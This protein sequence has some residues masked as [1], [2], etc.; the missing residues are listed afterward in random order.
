MSLLTSLRISPALFA[1][2]TS[3]LLF[4]SHPTPFIQVRSALYLFWL[5]KIKKA[6]HFRWQLKL[7]WWDK[8]IPLHKHTIPCL[9]SNY[10]VSLSHDWKL[11]SQNI[12]SGCMHSLVWDCHLL[13]IIW[14]CLI[15]TELTQPDNNKGRASALSN[16][17][18]AWFPILN[19]FPLTLAC[20]RT[21]CSLKP[22]PSASCQRSLF[23]M[24]ESGQSNVVIQPMLE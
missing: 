20:K 24:H 16:L 4:A 12:Y 8:D 1:C 18:I 17:T 9:L 21:W 23:C 14:C 3:R 2:S 11:V 6:N 13:P 22:P 15:G 10:C 5:K 7:C 19:C